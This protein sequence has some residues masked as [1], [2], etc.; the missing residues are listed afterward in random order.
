MKNL[1]PINVE[2]EEAILGGI[3]IDPEAIGRVRELISAE[4]FAI[5]SHQL[6]W[7]GAIELN[8]QG[9]STDL[10]AMATWLADHGQLDLIGG[11]ARL[12]QLVERTVSAVN[13]DQYA[14]LIEDK[15]RRRELIKVGNDLVSLG[16]QVATELPDILN[17]AEQKVFSVTQ[18]QKNQFRVAPIGEAINRMMF[19]LESEKSPALP[20]GLL[21]LDELIG[22]FRRQEMIVVAAPPS[23]G[24]T[25]FGNYAAH[26]VASKHK[27]PVVFFTAE[28][29]E[30][31][32]LARF[33]ASL[34]G[35]D[36]QKII[37][38]KVN[39]DEAAKII[40]AMGQLSEL[41]IFIDDTSGPSLSP[42]YMRQVCRQVVSQHGELGLIIIDYIQLLGDQGAVNRAQAVGEIS[43]HCKAIAKEF[44]CPLL[45]LAQV[46]REVSNRT[47]KR[48]LM[49][50]LRES[51]RIEQDA[52]IVIVLYREDYYDPNSS[53]KGETEI[54]VRKNR[55]GSMG[56][57]KVLFDPA[58][59]RFR[60]LAKGRFG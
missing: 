18:A 30:Q 53:S 5:Q 35:V 29:S 60:N 21:D 37:D 59:G 42:N 24:K 17:A 41:N 32:L 16:H 11:Q 23:A 57:A 27:L 51:G 13:I 19:A 44:N 12:A 45:A 50:D 9:R 7:R 28:M 36:V 38:H 6:I 15:Y 26:H 54:I 47:D 40:G 1:M 46:N 22:G 3:L 10:M 43:T 33:V 2:A 55:N 4:Y 34:S 56:T 20:T 39:H 48:P 58:I 25:W 8:S 49:S 31:L 14:A 52:D